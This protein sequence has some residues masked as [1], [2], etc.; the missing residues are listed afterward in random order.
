MATTRA[1]TVLIVNINADPGMLEGCHAIRDAIAALAP[2]LRVV[3][4]H[5]EGVDGEA[6]RRLRPAAV[7]I[8]PNETP[9]PAYPPAFDAFLAWVHHVSGRRIVARATCHA[10]DVLTAEAEALF[11]RID[12]AEMARRAAGRGGDRDG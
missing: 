10:N 1:T 5:W 12:M 9:F 2:A 6:A 8:G 4:R 3:V 11:V 7:V